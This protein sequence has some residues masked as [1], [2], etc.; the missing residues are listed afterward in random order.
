MNE[1]AVIN[2]SPLIFLSR[3]RHLDILRH[4]FDNV[5]VPEAVANEIRRKGSGDIT[6]ESL[7]SA[8]WIII[9]PTVPVPS[10][11]LEWGLGLG[12]SSVIA[13]AC[14]HQG[15]VA[16]LDDLAARKCAASMNLPIRGTL[17]IVLVAKQRGIIPSARAVMEDLIR[18][19]LYLS[20]PVLDA[21]LARVGE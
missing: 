13:Y 5:Y 18:G 17:G 20:G 3:G 6:V 4:F 7:D 10:M 21:A 15:T 14:Q 19:G 11:V 12:E 8:T 1:C 16:V 9:L 2:A